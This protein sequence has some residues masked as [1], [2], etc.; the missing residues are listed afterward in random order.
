M[1]VSMHWVFAR[2]VTLRKE[3]IS[4]DSMMVSGCSALFLLE[5]LLMEVY[6][7]KVLLG[8]QNAFINGMIFLEVSIK[9]L[10]LFIL[11]NTF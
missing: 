7:L 5:P 4:K 8:I 9:C 10:T 6:S 11:G 1:L 3:N 2:K